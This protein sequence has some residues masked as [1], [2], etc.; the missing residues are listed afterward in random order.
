M[1]L[2][3][4][5]SR[6]SKKKITIILIAALILFGMFELFYLFYS[7]RDSDKK[8]SNQDGGIVRQVLKIDSNE[9]GYSSQD[10]GDNLSKSIITITDTENSFLAKNAFLGFYNLPTS[11]LKW[12]EFHDSN[13]KII[14]INSLLSLIGSKIGSDVE[15]TIDI[16]KSS[17]F[18][19]ES[20]GN[21]K[22]ISLVMNMRLDLYKKDYYQN[23][24][25]Y[26]KQWE[27]SIL[28]DTANIFSPN[29]S[30]SEKDL[31]QKLD[32]SDG[33]YRYAEFILPD[34]SKS[35]IDY[36]I[37]DEYVIVSNS[38]NCMNKTIESLYSAGR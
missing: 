4:A 34:G 37:V 30:F 8:T 6:M 35:S 17:F 22:S 31:D 18:S 25:S 26:M 24:V 20:R 9:N 38:K 33:E 10:E 11:D 7:K 21:I 1:R 32:F 5:F 12:V 14:P 23:E 2:S 27:K 19:C 28:G 13:G 16:K 3:L 15:E 36:A 29:V